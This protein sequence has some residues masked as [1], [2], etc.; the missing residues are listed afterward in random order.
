MSSL[1]GHN[2][3]T[4]QAQTRIISVQLEQS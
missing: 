3:S 2:L 4:I 1:N